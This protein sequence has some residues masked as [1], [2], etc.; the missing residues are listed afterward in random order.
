MDLKWAYITFGAGSL[1][2]IIEYVMA[3]K[4]KGGITATDKKSMIGLFW[5]SIGAAGLV[6][7]LTNA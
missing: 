2:V 6:A 3:S 5:L 1:I 4:K 7:F